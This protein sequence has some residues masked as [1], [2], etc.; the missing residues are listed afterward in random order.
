MVAL[1]WWQVHGTAH[2]HHDSL[3]PCVT[4]SSVHSLAPSLS[5]DSLLP[6][7]HPSEICPGAL[8]IDGLLSGLVLVMGSFFHY[9]L[10]DFDRER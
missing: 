5:I 3:C 9:Y 10:L 1:M 8:F 2:S 6:S 7:T 4:F